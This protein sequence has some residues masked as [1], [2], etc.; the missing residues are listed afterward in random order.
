[1][2]SCAL[3]AATFAATTAFALAQ[4]PEGTFERSLTVSGPVELDVVTD[5]GGISVIPGP[6]GSVRI[7][8][9]LKGHRGRNWDTSEI[10][11]RIRAVERNPPVEQTGNRVRIGY[12]SD[13][14]LLKG[15]SIR[16][17]IQT[18]PET[19]LRA[20]ADSGGIRIEGI[21]GPADCHTD[22]GGIEANRIGS[23]VR[24]TADSGGI[25]IHNVKGPVYARADSGGIEATGVAGS[26]DV[27]TDSGGIRL[28][29][30][31]P[32]PV[33]A[34]AD[35]GGAKVKLAPAGGYDINVASSS[36]RITVPEMPVRGT[37]SRRHAEGKVRGGGPLVNIRVDSGNVDV[38]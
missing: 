32:A 2:N 13:R 28:A 18:P 5:S 24:A 10:E 21:T 22:S 7:H 26:I 38:E 1:M 14:N 12:V 11:S 33:H 20:R 4:Q 36:G 27:E 35:S 15:V 23:E 37:F 25:R 17:E 9:I 34:R 8:A 29:Q 16:L 30:T 3:A 19:R 6:A 31:T